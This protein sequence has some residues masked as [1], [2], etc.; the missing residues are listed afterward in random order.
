MSQSAARYVTAEHCSF[1]LEKTLL[2]YREKFSEVAGRLQGTTKENE[3]MKAAIQ[4]SQDKFTRKIREMQEVQSTTSGLE[5]SCVAKQ[6]GNARG[7]F[8]RSNETSPQK[9]SL[10][11]LFVKLSRHVCFAAH[12]RFCSENQ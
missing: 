9:N 7:P 4:Q 1:R 12:T 5:A 6:I 10:G 11:V 8:L 3:K 2:K